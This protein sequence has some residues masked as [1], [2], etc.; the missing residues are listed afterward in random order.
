M[1]VTEAICTGNRRYRAAEPLQPQGVVLH[2]IGTPQPDAAVLREFWQR[3]GGPYVTHYVLDDAKILH[4]MPDNYKCWHVGSPGNDRYLGIEMCEPRQIR[5][6]AGASFTVSDLQA[7]QQFAAAC[8]DNAVRLLAR[9]CLQHGWNP[10]EAVWT[11]AEITRRGLSRTDHV[12]PQH[13]WNGLGLGCDLARLRQAVRAAMGGSAPA[14][15]EVIYRIRRNWADAASQTG[16]YRNP[17][18]AKA[19][20]PPGYAVFDPAGRQV[21]PLARVVRVTASALNV[22]R[23]PS[24]D[25]A[26]VQ[27]LPRGG[28]YTVVAEQ[29][30]WGL[31]KAY[32][33]GRDGWICLR[34]TEAA[35]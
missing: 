9:L 15:E 24:A 31:L 19:A 22:R 18:Y 30:G 12:D 21:W 32:R 7:A 28:A 10:E 2:S 26:V 29:D 27:T 3:D 34:Y 8:R 14:A 1:T 20:C 4:C 6:T 33:S 13:L 5:Y 35:E 17:D 11:H 16:A 23:G 25:T